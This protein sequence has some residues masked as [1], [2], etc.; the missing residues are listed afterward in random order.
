M[1]IRDR[2]LGDRDK[3]VAAGKAVGTTQTGH[4]GGAKANNAQCALCHDATTI[5]LYHAQT[6][7]TPNNKIVQDGVSSI[8]YGISA[9]SVNSAGNVVV[10]FSITK[11]G[12]PV[13]S[14]AAAT[15][16][17]NAATGAV[18]A[19]PAFQ[20]IPGFVGGPSIYIAASVPQDGIATPADTNIST[21]VTLT[22]LLIASGSPKAGSIVADGKGN[23]TATITGDT[24]GQPVTAT[25]KQNTGTSA[26]TGNCVNPSPIVLPANTSVVMA[27]VRGHFTQVNLPAYPF[28]AQNVLVSP[29][30]AAVGGLGVGGVMVQKAA[31]GKVARRL[32]VDSAKCN[33]CH[34]RLGTSPNFHGGTT[35][36][37]SVGDSSEAQACFTCHTPNRTSSGW[38]ADASTFIHGI[39]GA[40]K[41]TVAFTWH[42]VSTTDNYSKL[43]YPGVLKDCNQCHL[44]NTVNFG[45][46]AAAVPNML[47]SAVATGKYNGATDTAGAISPYV[48]K[49]NVMNYG[50]GYS[51]VPAGAVVPAQTK[52][53]G[54]VV[55]QHV[56][57]AGGEIVAGDPAN[58][59]NSP[60]SSACSACHDAPTAKAH[61]AANGGSTYEARATATKKVESCL[62]CHGQGKE[63]DAAAVHQ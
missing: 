49:D 18:V 26:I 38:S 4:I 54:T 51:F 31:T 40:S 44:P 9:A 20:P 5:P 11:D 48:V 35:A 50:N 57:A 24:L 27:S 62:I 12:A 56:A 41:R 2:T 37:P 17:V 34:D 13:T 58:L 16:V 59:V 15:T 19:N 47:W 55:A 36:S 45:A 63:F 32:V 14:L 46:N 8:S 61:M 22:N 33:N 28:T 21:S 6:T 1:C 42:A 30:V 10:T 3:D 39:H 52:S 7:A 25:C 43:G 23:F 53:D 29:N 60:I